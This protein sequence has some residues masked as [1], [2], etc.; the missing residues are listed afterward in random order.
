MPLIKCTNCTLAYDSNVLIKDLSFTVNSG[1]YLCIVGKNGSGKS[2]LMHAI[3]G[4]KPL[5]GGKI[6]YCDSLRNTDIGF[7]PQH[8]NVRR[9][10][11]AS[12]FEVVL[13]G[14]RSSHLYHTAHDK[15]NA[16][17][18]LE[19][20]GIS[21]LK[22]RPF[23]ELSGG[24]R[25]RVLLAR[26]LFATK[27]L[28]LLD[29]PTSGLDPMATAELYDL[30]EKI[31]KSG[32]TVIT[33]SHDLASAMKYASHILQLGDDF[34]FFGTTEEYENSDVGHFYLGSCD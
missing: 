29:E 21:H 19:L 18:K 5:N 12:V 13:S 33:V 7:L 15:E 24:Q 20:L 32:I 22:K 26:A 23:A 1:D 9:D 16:E 30:I 34:I 11:P 3:L 25:Q 17:N 6:E 4:L 10:F 2:T 31:N 8:T 28:I 14:C 27:Q